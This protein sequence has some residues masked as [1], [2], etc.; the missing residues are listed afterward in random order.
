[1]RLM[2]I[3]PRRSGGGAEKVIASLATGLAERHEV[4]LVSMMEPKGYSYPLSERVT[5]I[6]LKSK[7]AGWKIMNR[8][9]QLLH[10]D[11]FASMRRIKKSL[12]Q[13]YPV[14]SL[15]RLK[16]SLHIDC[17]ISFLSPANYINT[18]AESSC[19]AIISIR[20]CMVG[21]YAPAEVNNPERKEQVLYSCRH[22]DRIVSVSNEAVPG[23]VN[24]F[25]ADPDKISVIYNPCDYQ[26]IRQLGTQD[27][28]DKTILQ[29]IEAAEFVFFS[30]GRIT[31]KKGQWHLLH[32][33]SRV[34]E[35]HPE[36]LLIIL[37]KAN[38]D[39]T[40]K[41][42]RDIINKKGMETH[43]ILAGFHAN[44]FAFLARGDAF[45]M[46]SFN[47]GFPNA[48]IE[49]MAL[50]LPVIS[51]DCSSGPR[52]ILA[53]GTVCTEK[54]TIMDP[55][56]YGI[57]IPECSGNKEINRSLEKNEIIMADAMIRLIED[58]VL[59]NHYAEQSRKRAEQ[60]NK[61]DFLRHW[62]T[63]IQDAVT[64]K[65]NGSDTVRKKAE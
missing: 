9:R 37:G 18:A 26:R 42:L 58:P 55:A 38:D 51:T 63:L 44:P 23:L 54:T 24:S 45:V 16:Q 29:R 4:F 47:E 32:A 6:N 33:F 30:N 3:I 48:L 5:V 2:F 53:P 57:L 36:A 25:E 46:S 62:E 12:S 19:P 31:E 35:T 8:I 7:P 49:A 64:E 15:K 65:K 28:E 43:V 40:D 59:R 39:G 56:E 10:L 27:P 60:F 61:E 13:N 11:R 52:E 17:S 22:A 41:L 20:S 34:L 14:H 21:K 50:G 1:M